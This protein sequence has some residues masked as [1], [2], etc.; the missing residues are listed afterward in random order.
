MAVLT[1]VMTV[2]VLVASGKG[3]VPLSTR[4]AAAAMVLLAMPMLLLLRLVS[5]RLGLYRFQVVKQV[6]RNIASGRVG[7]FKPVTLEATPEGFQIIHSGGDARLLW[8]AVQ[9]VA[10]DDNAIYIYTT[11]TAAYIVPRRAFADSAQAQ[12]FYE[13]ALRCVEAGKK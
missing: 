10:Q 12:E 7:S 8:T 6:R 9:G 13:A 11:A 1:C 3:K 5:R 2:A 4:L